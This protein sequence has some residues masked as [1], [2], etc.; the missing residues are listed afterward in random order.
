MKLELK[1]TQLR[2]LNKVFHNGVI[3]TIDC[4]SPGYVTFIEDRNE[5]S[6]FGEWIDLDNIDFI[7]LTE[8][9]LFKH[10]FKKEECFYYIHDVWLEHLGGGILRV[11]GLD[12]DNRIKYLHQIQ[13][14][15]YIL[16]NQEL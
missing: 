8:E 6:I 5:Q 15:V 9:V 3:K 16:A 10:G 1:N 12:L 11:D 7:L 14:T 13:N 2:R 4:I